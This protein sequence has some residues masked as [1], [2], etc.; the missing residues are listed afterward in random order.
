MKKR[1]R[2]IINPKSGTKG[3]Q[4]IPALIERATNHHLAEIEICFTEAPKHAISLAKEAAAQQFDIVVAVGGDGSA[5]ETAQGLMGSNTPLGIIPNGSGNGM[6]R[7][8]GIP[9]KHEAAI[10]VI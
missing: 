3:K 9:L 1:I 6:A 8:L 7:H 5:N 10:S 4:D 2:Y